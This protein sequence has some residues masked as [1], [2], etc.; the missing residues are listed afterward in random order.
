MEQE[1]ELHRLEKFVEKILTRFTALKEE[2]NQLEQEVFER[3]L[4]IEELR[5]TISS[6]VAERSE[7]SD[8]VNRIVD[9]IEE[10]EST[11]EKSEESAP[12]NP[13][14][15]HSDVVGEEPFSGDPRSEEPGAEILKVEERSEEETRRTQQNLFSAAESGE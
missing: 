4:L 7:I 1:S 9:Q 14:P 8:R 6:K 15:E 10:W 12:G 13:E 11:L 5:E 3:D 2:K